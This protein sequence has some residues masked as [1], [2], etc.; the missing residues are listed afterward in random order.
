M[1]LKGEDF[2]GKQ[3]RLGGRSRLWVLVAAALPAA[4]SCLPATAAAAAAQNGIPLLAVKVELQGGQEERR[5]Q[6]AGKAKADVH[7]IPP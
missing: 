3:G 1:V 4:R 7:N 6:Q 2:H 5:G